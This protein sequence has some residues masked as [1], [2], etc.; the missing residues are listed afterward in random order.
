M[1]AAAATTTMMHPASWIAGWAFLLAAFVSG[2]VIGLWFHRADFLG[3]YGAWRRR[4]IRL[5]HIALAALG[6]LNLIFA[7]S[8]C[9]APD[10]PAATV[11]T[12]GFVLGGV[13]MPACC[14]ACA[15]FPALRFA[16]AVPVLLLVAAAATVVVTG[17][18]PGG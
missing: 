8:P 10:T 5:A 11:A 14:V 1:L 6:M 9:P 16:F 7:L 18:M 12:L 15:F 2:G 13:T 4:L 3:G 17:L